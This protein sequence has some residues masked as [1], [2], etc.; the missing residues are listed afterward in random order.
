MKV[1]HA[2]EQRK[3]ADFVVINL[4]VLFST[5]KMYGMGK[6]ITR[7]YKLWLHDMGDEINIQRP[8]AV[9]GEYQLSIEAVKP[10][11]RPRDAD[12][13][14]KPV[15]DL[16][17][18]NGIVEDDSLAV[19]TVATWVDSSTFEG[20]RVTIEKPK[21]QNKLPILDELAGEY[22]KMRQSFSIEH[23]R[24][25]IA[26]ELVDAGIAYALQSDKGWPWLA[27]YWK[28]G[29]KRE[30]LLKSIC[31]LIAEI[32]RLDSDNDLV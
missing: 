17:V 6:H 28:P 3:K 20:M 30:D 1:N 19:S 21:P 23:D 25:Y 31:L 11:D 16:L 24:Q 27:K 18:R 12:N 13:L 5:N 29:R 8:R 10:D 7:K 2:F 9:A 22:H 14:L 32:E 15:S 4:P 26:D